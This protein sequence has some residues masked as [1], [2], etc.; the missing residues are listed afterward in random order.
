MLPSSDHGAIQILQAPDL[1][2]IR[3]EAIHEVRVIPLD[4]SPHPA[5]SLRS[6][7]GDA[8]GYWDGDTLVVETTNLNGRTGARGNGNELPTT[9]RLT[10][11]ERFTRVTADRI[12]VQ[13]TV[14]DEGTWTAPWTVTFPLA[15]SDDYEIGEYA[16]HE[17]NA[18]FLR[19][20]L[21]ASRAEEARVR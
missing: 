4:G 2:T 17:A 1:V 5:S 7:M 13:V 11:V 12:D 19:T 20:T 10:I 8:R 21:G 15:R 3:T 16:C 14:E 18:S 6:Y 9:E